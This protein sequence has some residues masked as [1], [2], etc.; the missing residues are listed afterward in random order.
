[1]LF[2]EYQAWQQQLERQPVAFLGREFATR[3]QHVREVLG[4]FLHAPADE[5][6]LVANATI[7]LNTV[8]RA[9]M[10]GWLQ[11]GDEILTSEHEYN[12]LNRTWAFAAHYTGAKYIQH[13]VPLPLTTPEAFVEAFWQGVTPRTKII[14]LSHITSPTALTLPIA[15]ICE[16]ARAAGIMTIIDGAHAPGHLP[17]D[18]AAL[19]ADVYSGNCHKWL[20]TPKGSAFLHVRREHHTLIEPLVISHDWVDA[21]PW[22]Q[23]NQWQ[24]TRDIA[25]FLTI[26]AALEFH[27]QPDW[28]AA[29]AAAQQLAHDTYTQ[30]Q[31]LFELPL[32]T[33]N[34]ETWFQHM[35]AL[36]LPPCDLAALKTR[37]Y[38]EFRLEIPV[39]EHPLLRGVRV[40]YQGYNTAADQA[41]LLGALRTIFQG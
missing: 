18:L 34:D 3:M 6:A 14:F 5:L 21:E 26:P 29:R 35:V 41:A 24:G 4:A 36:P 10:L 12:A 1:V 15:T 28:S 30:A 19:G 39:I 38:D 20:C 16:R 27:T 23:Q 33:P 22:A 40:S 11:A 31:A 17:L 8:V 2:D 13:P 32:L 37:L 25:A 9:L 7:G